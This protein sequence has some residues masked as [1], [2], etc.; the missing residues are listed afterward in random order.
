MFKYV[1]PLLAL[2]LSAPSFAAKTTLMLS[3]KDSVNYLGWSTE[4]GNVARQEVYRGTTSNADLRERIAVLDADTRTFQDTGTN[5]GINYWYWVDVVGTTQEQSPSNAV[6]TA[7]QKG[8]LRAAQ[9]ASE[10]KPGA[11]FENRN[12]DCGGVTIGT[13]C[14]NDSDKQK[15]LIILK[16]ASV[17]NLRISASGGA[18]GIH[19]ESGNCTIENVIWEDVCEDAATNNGKTM[20]IIGGIAHNANGGYGGKPDKVLQQN[21]KN[22]TTV[23]KG[24]F[25]LTGEHGKLWRSCGDCTNNGGPRFLSVDGL[26]VNGTIGSIAGVNRNYGDVATLKNIKIK[27]YKAGKPKV[28][29]EYIGVEKG[30]GESKKY[31]EEDQWNTANC[32][33]SRSDVTKL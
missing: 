17:K 14:P 11:T 18:D 26:I 12:V 32:K 30:N 23:V 33:V 25:T 27:D 31:K 10:C 29:E 22:S 6:T 21:A 16:N 2:T 8:L 4:E 20:T 19:C 5:S 7:P 13:S 1:L 15:P 24:N 28:C 3:Q 9:A